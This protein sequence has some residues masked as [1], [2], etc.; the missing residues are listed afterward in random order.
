MPEECQLPLHPIR[1]KKSIIMKS[2][3]QFQY[4]Q[5]VH[6]F[7]V[8][9][10]NK[11]QAEVFLPI[12]YFFIPTNSTKSIFYLLGS[13]PFQ[14]F[15]GLL[16]QCS[17]VLLRLSK[18]VTDKFLLPFWS[19]HLRTCPLD[20]RKVQAAWQ[21]KW[22]LLGSLTNLLFPSSQVLEFRV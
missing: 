8:I 14:Q 2:Q 6:S 21:R 3:T 15:F 19:P 4:N 16:H 13:K 9:A 17:L 12:N 22:M 7:L 1:L 11:D 10:L 20:H 18:R 5:M